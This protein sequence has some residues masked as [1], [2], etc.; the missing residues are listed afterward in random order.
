MHAVSITVSMAFGIVCL[1]IINRFVNPYFRRKQADKLVEN[2]LKGKTDVDPRCLEDPKYGTISSNAVCLQIIGPKREN[3]TLKW[4]E[5]EQV[6]AFKRDLW[7][8]DQ[9]CLSFK[10]AGAKCFEINEEMAGYYDLLEN[11][12]NHLPN[13]NME[14]ILDVAFPA[15]ETKHRI[16]WKKSPDQAAVTVTS[17]TPQNS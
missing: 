15:F 8:V 6:H 10:T 12:P 4:D 11:L 5:I 3:M 16:I 13:F 14:W 2:L 7:T 9:I 17:P 1:V